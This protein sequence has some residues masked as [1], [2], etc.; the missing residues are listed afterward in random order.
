MKISPKEIAFIYAQ[1]NEWLYNGTYNDI[2][3]TSTN[4]LNK[5]YTCDKF[6]QYD[7]TVVGYFTIM[8]KLNE[9]FSYNKGV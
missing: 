4:L 3:T 5:F 2:I 9:K 6:E 7:I 8:D 1:N